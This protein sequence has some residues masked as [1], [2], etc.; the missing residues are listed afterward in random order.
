MIQ[1]VPDTTP[2]VFYDSSLPE[3]YGNENSSIS[4][5]NITKPTLKWLL[6]IIALIIVAAIAIGVS[7]G[8]WYHR[9]HL[10]PKSSPLIRYK[11]RTS[12]VSLR[13]T[14][15]AHRHRKI[16]NLHLVLTIH[17]LHN[18]SLMIRL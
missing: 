1:T 17:V 12:H 18:L 5:V 8:I 13:L 9:E 2:Q 11:L 4:S 6:M 10:S 14:L 16:Q 7:L 3:V 15:I